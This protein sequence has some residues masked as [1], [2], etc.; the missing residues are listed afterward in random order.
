MEFRGVWYYIEQSDEASKHWFTMLQLLASAQ[1]PDVNVV[2]PM[3]TIP[4]T[5]RR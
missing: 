4:V 1:V 5:S 3:L 2:G